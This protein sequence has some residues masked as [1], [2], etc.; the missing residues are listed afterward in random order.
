MDTSP[1]HNQHIKLLLMLIK[2]RCISCEGEGSDASL[3]VM[4]IKNFSY[5]PCHLNHLFLTFWPSH[6]QLKTQSSF[7]RAPKNPGRA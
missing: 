7:K 6:F 2:C 3:G 5:C 4:S 1:A